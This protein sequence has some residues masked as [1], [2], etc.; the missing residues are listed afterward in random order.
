L[1]GRRGFDPTRARAPGDRI[2]GFADGRVLVDARL[3]AARDPLYVGELDG[4]A[5]FAAR[6]D[7]ADGAITL[8]DALGR[9]SEPEAA[10]AGRA[11]QLLDWDAG[12]R[13][14]GRCGAPTERMPGEAARA[15]PSCGTSF[16]P[17]ISPAAIML[18]SRG[19]DLLLASRAGGSGFYSVL[20]GFVEPGESLEQTVVREVREEVGIEVDGVRY[21]GSQPWPFPGQLMVGFTAEYAGGELD[22]DASEIGDARWF[23]PGDEL[24]PIPPPYSIARQL[25]DAFL[26]RR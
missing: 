9:L 25:I 6:L 20:A 23:A 21:F 1:R 11:S 2:F 17:R 5:C 13:F 22:P 24:P 10:A 14:C 16:Y 12:H 8:R 19:D 3:V 7:E 18:V 4:A 15:C 26:A